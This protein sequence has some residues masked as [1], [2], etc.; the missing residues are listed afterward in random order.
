M[1]L[2]FGSHT[3]CTRFTIFLDKFTES[4]PGI[5]AVDE[6]HCLILTGMSGEDV[7][8]LVAENLEPE[9]IGIRD[10]YETITVLYPPPHIPSGSKQNGR[11]N[12]TK[13]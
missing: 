9:V 11:K 12:P 5:I 13:F 6:V 7:V 3:S 10:V 8:V 4:G 1:P 2:G